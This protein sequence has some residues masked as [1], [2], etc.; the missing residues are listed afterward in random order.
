MKVLHLSA[1]DEGG[2]GRAAI[3]L[4]RALIADG[5]DSTML[6]NAKDSTDWRVQAKTG[7][8]ADVGL[9]TRILVEQV[10]ALVAKLPDAALFSPATTGSLRASDRAGKAARPW[11]QYLATAPR[12]SI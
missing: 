11:L 7:L 8:L 1:G 12:Y 3:R 10:P 2:A 5:V 9:R 6:V 4:H